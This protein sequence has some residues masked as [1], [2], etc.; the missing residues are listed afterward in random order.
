ML[1]AP[2]VFSKDGVAVGAEVSH[3]LEGW[4]TERDAD[5]AP[6]KSDTKTPANQPGQPTRILLCLG[7]D[8]LLALGADRGHGLGTKLLGF[9]LILFFLK[10]S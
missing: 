5:E 8:G 6:E 7:G 3:L 10:F 9:H 2:V 4:N 1:A